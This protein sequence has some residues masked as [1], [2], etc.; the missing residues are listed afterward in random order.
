M[1]VNQVKLYNFRN[2]IDENVEF[3]PGI[4][5]ITGE[6]AQ[7]KTNLIESI[8]MLST[9]HGFR[10]RYDKELIRFVE[11]F[12]EI[13]GDIF[14]EGRNQNINIKFGKGVRK[15]I[16]C[17]GVK[18]NARELSQTLKVVL[19]CPN[20]LNMIKEG[21]ASRRRFTDMAISQLRPGYVALLSDYA[22]L[23]EHKRHILTDWHDKPSLLETLDDFSNSMCRISA[24]IIRFRAS[25]V[26]KLT[27][28]AVP[29][30]SEFSG[31][32]EVLSIN[33]KTVSTVTNPFAS[34]SE[35]YKELLEHQKA[36]REAEIASGNIL[37]GIHKDDLIIEINGVNARSYA[38]QG[39]TRTAALSLKM[40]ERELSYSDTGEMPILLLDDVL[41]ELDSKRQE[42]VL[43]LIGGGQTFITCCEDEQIKNRSGGKVILVD[44]GKINYST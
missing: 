11:N 22:K 37:T 7:G 31:N 5:V 9:G 23:Y 24:Q 42:Y 44:N 10:T 20:D 40:A 13:N 3:S 18:K 16:R 19:F 15:Q 12:A 8:F 41:S 17:N 21:A 14:S 25:F 2:Y 32:G 29:I 43:N 28:A 34:A 39:Q 30:H 26:E 33:Y 27:T 36:H 35:I 1:I 4:N 6:N 38:S